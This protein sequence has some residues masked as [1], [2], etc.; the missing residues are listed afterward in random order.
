MLMKVVQSV[1]WIL[2]SQPPIK[3]REAATNDDQAQ[4]I[5]QMRLNLK[6]CQMEVK[7]IAWKTP[8]AA[9]P[10]WWIT[11][12]KIHTLGHIVCGFG[13]VHCPWKLLRKKKTT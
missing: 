12:S 5:G 1:S 13:T 10:K 2:V 4:T 9:S 7:S 3:S 11:N 6:L 8:G